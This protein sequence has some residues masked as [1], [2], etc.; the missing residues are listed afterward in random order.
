MVEYVCLA[1]NARFR[2]LSDAVDHVFAAHPEKAGE[3]PSAR[4]RYWEAY[5]QLKERRLL[6]MIKGKKA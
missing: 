4:A 5:Y 6:R 1:C 2:F 3:R